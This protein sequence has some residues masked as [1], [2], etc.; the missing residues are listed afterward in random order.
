MTINQ[1]KT[2]E[3]W[4][5]FA[6]L[7]LSISGVLSL[8]I[9]LGKIPSL[10]PYLPSLQ[11]TQWSLVIHVILA[12]II[13]HLAVP[14]GLNYYLSSHPKPALAK[15]SLLLCMIG[16]LLLFFALPSNTSKP[17]LIN[18]IPLIS[19]PIFTSGLALCMLGLLGGFLSA[20]K[21]T[22]GTSFFI[23]AIINLVIG[24]NSHRSYGFAEYIMW[25]PGHL[26]QHLSAIFL[27]ISWNI[28]LTSS[29]SK[30]L[31]FSR[32]LRPS[33]FYMFLNLF[34]L[35]YL[36]SLSITSLEYREAFTFLMR[37]GIFPAFIIFFLQLL[38]FRN[39]IEWKKID[40]FRLV[41]FIFS[42]ILLV[43]GFIFGA[44]IDGYNLKIP[45]HY[46][47]TIGAV[48]ISFMAIVIHMLRKYYPIYE[49][50][51]SWLFCSY[52]FG[53]LLF[54]SGLFVAGC[55]EVE[56]KTY[57]AQLELSHMGKKIGIGIVSLGGSFALLGGVL[58]AF[59]FMKILLRY[60]KGPLST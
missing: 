35:P 39:K 22:L 8:P 23:A 31:I 41:A 50:K 25:G 53:Q 46:H 10:A 2:H 7:I 12:L 1:N 43:V 5:L 49:K 36:F 21:L 57:G 38:R 27:L 18:Y 28:L 30:K 37:W 32:E 44:F 33:L 42:S 40:H 29:L 45:G 20:G 15:A 55:F 13:W 17:L 6:G 58:F 4:F 26:L 59:I 52:G 14:V 56:R 3:L 47:A 16:S 60:K 54:A 24:I 51:I 9:F 34:F 11:W 48:T 19:S